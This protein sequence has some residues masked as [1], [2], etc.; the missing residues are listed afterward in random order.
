[1]QWFVKKQFPQSLPCILFFKYDEAM[2][3]QFL[4]RGS[5]HK[6]LKAS[7]GYSGSGIKVIDSVKEVKEYIDAYTPT[8]QFQ[9]WIL[10]DALETISTFQGYKFHLRVWIVVVVQKGVISIY[11]NNNHVY[12]FSKDIYDIQ[13]IKEEDVYNSHQY[14]NAKNAFFPMERPDGW[15]VQE[16]EQA[17]KEMN[18][19]FASIFR[20]QNKFSPDWQMKN[21]YELFGADVLFDKK[22]N[23]SIIE[24]N[25]KTGMTPSKIMCLPEV[26]HLGLGGAPLKLFTCL[27][28]T[29]LGRTTPFTKPLTTFYGTQYKT[30]SEVKDAFQTLFHTK[31]E[32]EADRAYFEHQSYK[33]PSVR[34]TRKKHRPN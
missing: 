29:S 7:D 8:R 1:M 9:G 4:S 21:G 19:T 6:F 16:T 10:Q 15:T 32:Q 12:V 17:V 5:K 25:A 11:I 33:L 14:R 13:K 24:I 23:M 26:F 31:L 27:H 22:R 30:V 34:T 18:R 28:G 2:I 3:K 20:Q